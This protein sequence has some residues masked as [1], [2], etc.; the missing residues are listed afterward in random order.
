M[1]TNEEKSETMGVFLPEDEGR[2][3]AIFTDGEKAAQFAR[4]FGRSAIVAPATGLKADK[5]VAAVFES[6]NVSTDVTPDPYQEYVRGELVTNMRREMEAEAYRK[7]AKSEASE[8]AQE[9]VEQTEEARKNAQEATE[10][11]QR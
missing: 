4:T 9:T 6:R 10:Q 5:D 8:S 7:A 3:V 1:P 2:P 11:G